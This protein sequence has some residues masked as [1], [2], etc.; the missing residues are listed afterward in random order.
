MMLE[1]RVGFTRAVTVSG[2]CMI[3]RRTT[4]DVSLLTTDLSLATSIYGT[5][6]ERHV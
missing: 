6:S 5:S 3:A 1:E 2:F 4:C